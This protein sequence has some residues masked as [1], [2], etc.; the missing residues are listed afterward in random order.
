MDKIVPLAPVIQL[1]KP[2]NTIEF[3]LLDVVALLKDIPEKKLVTGQVGTI[4]EILGK[5]V[6]EVE[7]CNG[8]GVTIAM[9][10]LGKRDLL[11]LHYEV[12][13]A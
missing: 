7:F 9:A 4:V 1:L 8:L 10:A 2:K 11:L 6:F 5:D 3:K 13:T 12:E